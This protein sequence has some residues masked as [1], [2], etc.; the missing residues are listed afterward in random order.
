MNRR[1]NMYQKETKGEYFC[2]ICHM[3]HNKTSKIGIKHKDKKR[4]R[5]YRPKTPAQK[6]G[7]N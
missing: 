4:I 5:L 3:M 7:W 6:L 2:E 1:V